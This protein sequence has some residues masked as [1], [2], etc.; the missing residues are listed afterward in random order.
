MKIFTKSFY[1]I[2][3]I[4]VISTN[5]SCTKDSKRTKL[6]PLKV[7]QILAL[8][9]GTLASYSEL[10][11]RGFDLAVKE[12]NETGGINGH[13]L[14][15]ISEDSAL[16]PKKAISAYNKLVSI[17]RVHIIVGCIGSSVCLAIAPLATRDKIVVMSA[18]GTSPKLSGSSKYFFRVAPSDTIGA[19]RLVDWVIEAGANR[20]SILYIK[21]DYGQGQKDV[22]VE[23]LNFYGK[24]PVVVDSC[25]PEASDLRPQ[26]E[27]IR[28]SS[29]DTILLLT[30]APE[31][32]YF[33]KQAAEFN[34][35][36]KA[37]GG[38]GLSDPAIVNIARKE[39]DGVRFL[40][41][42]LG[43]GPRY[44]HFAELFKKEYNLE[45]DAV[46]LKAYSLMFVAAEALRNASYDGTDIKKYLSS[47]QI[48][49]AM[50][51]VSFNSDG[52]IEE[53]NFDRLYYTKGKPHRIQSQF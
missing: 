49:T 7:G 16:D 47:C 15:V 45:P 31:A 20:I 13:P 38:D 53:I 26:I 51:K 21:N 28:K 11:K 50:G 14:K 41:P 22:A 32:G 46:A 23:R 25:L 2:F 52:D 5:P 39:A 43:S 18:G 35:K 27:R 29:P 42:S 34:F 4:L 3:I 6:A 40:L 48:E 1:C 37:Y 44:N 17:D 24:K 9:G 36:F 19:T 12:I 30:H 10:E 8:T 33:L